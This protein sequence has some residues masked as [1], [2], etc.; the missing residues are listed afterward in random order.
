M[1]SVKCKSYLYNGG[2][3]GDFVF[4]SPIIKYTNYL[5]ANTF[6]F[7]Q[8]LGKLYRWTLVNEKTNFLDENGISLD[9]PEQFLE[10]ILSYYP[11]DRASDCFVGRLDNTPKRFKTSLAIFDCVNKTI[12]HRP[13]RTY[14]YIL[15]DDFV[16]GFD[17]VNKELFKLN[18]Q[19]EHVWT[20]KPEIDFLSSKTP[21]KYNNII[22]SSL[23]PQQENRQLVEG[24]GHYSFSGGLIV[25]LNDADGSL[26]W[27]LD[28]LN[29]ADQM[30]L[31]DDTLYVASLNEILLVSPESGQV[32]HIIDT[33]TSTPVDR[34]FG[35]TLYVD[36]S[37]IYYS[38]YDDALILIYDV[39]TYE[40]VKRIELPEGYHAHQHN[41][42][43][44]Q[45]GKQYFSLYNRTQYVA[46]QPILEIDLSDLDSPIEFEQEPEMEVELIT[47]QENS[48]EQELLI[49]MKTPSLDD[50]LRFG[51]IHTRDYAQWH[52]FNHMGMTFADRKPTENFNGIIR[53]IY[54]GCDQPADV[55]KQHLAMMEQRF[56]EWNAKEGFY[57]HIDKQQLT[58]LIATYVE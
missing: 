4:E 22:V 24:K 27:K 9:L 17:E 51:E 36:Q 13:I 15:M 32:I 54:S 41:F 2:R 58:K 55:V 46:Q 56:E 19:L 52:S 48:E 11:L 10:A 28:I 29:A 57:S 43:D 34:D 30:L 6:Y 38:H 47:S 40:L 44:K 26:V 12:V 45:T 23:G 33:Q 20:Y 14:N 42:Y 35:L 31:A 50:A 39:N 21:I 37:Y 49:T 8:I 16:Y 3:A 1:P 18:L 5:Q 53:F 25:G 7:Y